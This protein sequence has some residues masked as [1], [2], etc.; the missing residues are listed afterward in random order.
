LH[1]NECSSYHHKC[2]TSCTSTRTFWNSCLPLT[3]CRCEWRMSCAFQI[4]SWLLITS[5]ELRIKCLWT[6]KSMGCRNE[7]LA[8]TPWVA[9]TPFIQLKSCLKN[10]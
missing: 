5:C 6:C 8:L 10:L 1:R 7:S 9:A 3:Q 2:S 4:K